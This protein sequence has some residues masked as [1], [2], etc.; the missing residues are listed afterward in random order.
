MPLLRLKPEVQVLRYFP[1]QRL[2]VTMPK[3]LVSHAQDKKSSS[4]ALAPGQLIEVQHDHLEM[5]H[6]LHLTLRC[7]A[8]GSR[9]VSSAT[10]PF[11]TLSDRKIPTLILYLIIAWTYFVSRVVVICGYELSKSREPF[12]YEMHF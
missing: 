11:A 2:F 7:R 10:N 5:V 1:R 6:L 12:D 4:R 3:Q 9:L 8:L